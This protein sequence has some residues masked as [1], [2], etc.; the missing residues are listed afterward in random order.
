MI[1]HQDIQNASYLKI[2]MNNKAYYERKRDIFWPFHLWRVTAPKEKP[3]LNIFQ[4]LLLKLV[5]AGCNSNDKLSLYSNLNIDLIRHILQ[6]LMSEGYLI[7]W[8]L[9]EKAVLFL[10]GKEVNTQETSSYYLIQDAISGTM[11]PRVLSSLSH[12]EGMDFSKEYP[13]FRE[14]KAK[15]KLT[16]P[17]L[18]R[19]NQ[20]AEQSQ[21][22][23]EQMN[24][25]LRSYKREKNRYKQA[26]M[27]DSDEAFE[28]DSIEFIEDRPIVVFM[29]MRLFSAAGDQPWYLSDPTGLTLALAELRE[30]ADMLIKSNKPF[31]S[32]IDD[33]MGIASQEPLPIGERPSEIRIKPESPQQTIE[34]K[35]DVRGGGGDPGGYWDLLDHYVKKQLLEK[36][37]FWIIGNVQAKNYVENALTSKFEIEYIGVRDDSQKRGK[38]IQNLIEQLVSNLQKTME[39]WVKTLNVPNKSNKEWKNL[40][41]EYEGRRPIFQKD[42]RLLKIMYE[43]AGASEQEADQLKHVTCGQIQRA[44]EVGDQSLKALLAGILLASPKEV[45][46]EVNQISKDYPGWLDKILKLARDRND[47]EHDS[48]KLVTQEQ[49]FEHFESVEK[50]LTV[51]QSQ[52]E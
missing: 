51:M 46:K 21:P 40:V 44:V 45:K 9:T 23:A 25:C 24:V 47:A 10:E 7:N 39:A 30:S 19:H 26:D 41:K 37:Y 20:Q 42:K 35:E 11:I 8:A 17:F 32:L 52:R 38:R 14:N 1:S 15:G 2:S 34:P 16:K 50:L 27:Y 18:V 4:T 3:P 6:E 29:H 48:G 5:R 36:K 12:I 28:D 43:A 13:Q 31:A 49:A 33:V 22:T